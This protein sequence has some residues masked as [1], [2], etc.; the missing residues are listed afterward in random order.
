MNKRIINLLLISLT[1]SISVFA[2]GTTEQIEQ[3]QTRII[4]DHG[5]NEVEIPT[6]INRIIMTTL[7]PLPAVYCLF[8]GDSSKL[9]GIS[10]ASMAAAKNSILKDVLP[11]VVNIP[12]GFMKSG[13]DINIEEVIN[14][15]PDVVFYST[16]YPDEGKMYEEAGIPAVAF[17][18][19]KWEGD[20]IDTF[21]GWV[22][23]LGEVL[24]EKDH[25]SGVVTYGREIET[26]IADRIKDLSDDEKPKAFMLFRYANGKINTSGSLHFGQWWL[27]STGA[28]N[29]A[30]D[31][32]ENIPAVNMEQIYQWNPEMIFISNFAP[33]LPEDLYNNAIA[34]DNWSPIDAVKNKQVFKFPLGMY[35]WYP[36]ASDTPLSLLWLAK[37]IHPELFTDINMDDEIKNYYKQFYNVELTDEQLSR[38]YN[39]KREAAGV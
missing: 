36:P 8:A 30:Q 29:V 3:K 26:K 16:T 24:N 20:A 2:N 32:K 34:S 17:S 31:I 35:R 21:S 4:V 13:S 5:D 18:P 39:P 25:A 9:V 7:T 15:K 12:T 6:E 27:E 10:P 37:T 33:V 1:V 22:E 11:D 19:Y 23:L 38:I 14:L 28:I